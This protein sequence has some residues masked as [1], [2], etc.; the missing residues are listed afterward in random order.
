MYEPVLWRE[1]NHHKSEEPPEPVVVT[2]Q[3]IPSLVP[4]EELFAVLVPKSTTLCMHS[5]LNVD[6]SA[7]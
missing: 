1:V 7:L 5:P 3:N 2:T 4:N 6:N